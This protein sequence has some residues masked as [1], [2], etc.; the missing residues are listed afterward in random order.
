MIDRCAVYEGERLNEGA[1]GRLLIVVP[2]SLP[3]R[4]QYFTRLME[5]SGIGVVVNRRLVE[6]RL[7]AGRRTN[8]RRRQDRRGPQHVFGYFQGCSIVVQAG[9]RAT[10]QARANQAAT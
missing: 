1:T 4:A 5:G 8:D 3:S 10:S 2:P 9:Q 7:H 6:R